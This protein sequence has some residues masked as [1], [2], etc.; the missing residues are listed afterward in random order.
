MDSR[1]PIR[2]IFIAWGC[3][4]FSGAFLFR[5]ATEFYDSQDEREI[6]RIPFGTFQTMASA[7]GQENTPG[8]I[9]RETAEELFQE[10]G[11]L[12]LKSGEV[13]R[14]KGSLSVAQ[15]PYTYRDAQNHVIKKETR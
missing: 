13:I 6:F 8:N 4:R 12:G 9:P 10:L 15:L 3:G 1:T 11:S 5:Y 7:V 2:E 14:H